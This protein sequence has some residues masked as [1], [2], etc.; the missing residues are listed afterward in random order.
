MPQGSILGP[1]LFNIDL[2]YLFSECEIYKFFHGLSPSIMKNIFQVN[3]NNAYSLRS[4]NEL[5]CRNPK[6]AKYGT[7]TISYLA[8]KIWPLV[9]EIIKNSKTLDVFKNKI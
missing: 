5:Y 8:Q 1:L 4:L 3:T 2:I 9:P 6:T 7:E